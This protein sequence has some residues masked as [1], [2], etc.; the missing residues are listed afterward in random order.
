MNPPRESRRRDRSLKQPARPWRF[1][2]WA[3]RF[4]AAAALAVGAGYVPYHLYLRSGLA[5]F[6]ALRGELS[7][8]E[9]RNRKLRAEVVELRLQ[10]ERFAEGGEAIEQVARDELGLVRS[11]EIVFK[12]E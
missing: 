9:A 4:S 6:V 3:L 5:H 1:F 10:L 2:L 7:Q 8:L 12:V 11:G